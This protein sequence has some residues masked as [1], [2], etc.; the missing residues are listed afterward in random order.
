MRAKSMSRAVV[1]LLFAIAAFSAQ[2]TFHLVKVVEVFPGTAASPS[3]QYVVI[4]MYA[5]GQEFVGGHAITVFN[6]AGTQVGTFTFAGNVG[7][8]ANQAKILIATPQA[9]AFFGVTPDLTMTAALISAGGK[10]CWAGTLDC[11]AWGAYTGGTA[12]VG[13]PFNA[14]GGGLLSGRAAIRRLDIAGSASVLDAGDDT[15]NCAN[16]FV[17]GLP[18]PRNNAGVLGTVPAATCGNGVL[19][20]LEQCDDHN[21]V[22]G[23]GCSSTCTVTAVVVKHVIGDY[24][25]DGKSD[26]FW[27]NASTGANTIWRSG[28]NA[29]TQAV[30]GVT[31]LS[32]EVVGRGDFNGDGKADVF[33][34]NRSTGAN[35]IWKSANADT[36]QAVTGVTNLDWKVVGIGDFD[37]DGKSDVFW[38]NLGTGA[39]T[40]WKSGNSATRLATAGVTSQSWHVVGV[41]DFNGDGKSDVFWRNTS[42]GANTIWKSGNN[43]TQQPVAGVTNQSWKMVATGDF[44][45]DGKSDV[46]W[47]NTSTGANTIWK[48]AS[49]ATQQAT[50]ALASASWE[51]VSTGDYSGDGK[52]DVFWRNTG[53]GA[54]MIWKSG[55]S[56]TP[57]AVSGITNLAWHVVPYEGQALVAPSAMLTIADVALAEGNSGATPATFTVKLSPPSAFPVTYNI[58]TA[59][60]TATSGTD[61]VASS[62]SAQTIAA[63]ATSRSFVVS[64]NGDVGAEPNE[65]FAVNLSSVT[66][67]TVGDGHAQGTIMNDD[68][69]LLSIGNLSVT[70]GNSGTLL[71]SFTVQLSQPASSAVSYD[72]AT[73]DGTAVAG[74]DYAARSLAGETIAA[75][76]TSRPFAV[77]VYGDTAYEGNETFNVNV[78][79]VIAATVA[80]GHAS[81]TIVNDDTPYGY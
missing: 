78:S 67:A 81:G 51:V 39:D 34:R 76:S 45:G 61:Y 80:D 38:R 10:V 6:G 65:T 28:S 75:G 42:T 11:V 66:G 77:T 33:W 55:N 47:R 43:A 37:G 26:V 71:A 3:A 58:A 22:N 24:N 57:Q 1:A 59:A 30:K 50:T 52:S 63:G 36:P 12:G 17:S 32:W 72:I 48:S 46:F 60:G 16:D 69:P 20:G 53:S 29:T 19:E 54:N 70:E 31:S 74:S 5:S 49:N 13:T 27:R 64:I 21:L 62:L 14:S 40:I 2:A 18:A 25:G 79:N 4:Q 7:N 41:G 15:D 44:N 35:T 68:S 73:A 23:D 56:A 8:G 9:Q